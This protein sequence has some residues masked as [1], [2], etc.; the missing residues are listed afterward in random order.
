M[1]FFSLATAVMAIPA[2]FAGPVK[3]EVRPGANGFSCGTRDPTPEQLLAT[4]EI[5]ALEVSGNSTLEARQSVNVDVY[6][7][8][9]ASSNSLSGG[10]LTVCR[11]TT[12]LTQ[13]VC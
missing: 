5:A 1:R 7:H 2:V 11:R 6:F 9:V 3:P 12:S 4:Q 13:L 8:V 10:Y